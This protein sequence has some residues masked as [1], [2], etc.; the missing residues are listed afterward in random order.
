MI[1]YVNMQYEAKYEAAASKLFSLVLFVP[2][3][4]FHAFQETLKQLGVHGC[5]ISSSPLY[6]VSFCPEWTV[7]SVVN[8]LF[9]IVY[10]FLCYIRCCLL[11]NCSESMLS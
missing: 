7:W 8:N 9:S 3:I 5:T 6:P 11:Q 10:A 4:R 2:G 1:K